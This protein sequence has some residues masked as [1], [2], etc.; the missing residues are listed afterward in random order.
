MSDQ[1]QQEQGFPLP[2]II[3][4]SVIVLGL[5]ALGVKFVIS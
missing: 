3:M 1:A 5:V 2:L 4:V